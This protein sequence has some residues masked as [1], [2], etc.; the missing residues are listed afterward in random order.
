MLTAAAGQQGLLDVPTL[1]FAAVCVVGFLGMLLLTTWLQQREVR[2]LAW[3][4]SAY[5]I[6]AAAIAQWGAPEPTIRLP[7]EIPEAVIF[8]ACGIVWNGVRLFHG[9]SLWPRAVFGGAIVWLIACQ[10]DGIEEG[11]LGRIVAGAV[12]IAVYTF[13]IAFELARERR[14]SAYSRLAAA[15]VPSF[16]AGMFM[17]PLG[18]Q[19][20]LPEVFAAH[21]LTVLALEAIF[22]AVGTAF[23]LLMMVKDHHV[24]FYRKAAT[25]DGLTGLLNRRAFIEAATAM[26]KA[27]GARGE[28]V[29]LLMFD[30]DHFK[31][32]NDRFGHATGDSV[33]KVFA[34]TATGSV[35]A[36]DIVARLGG[37]EFVAMVP[38]SIEGACHVAERLRAAYETAGLMVDDIAVGSTVSIGLATSYRPVADIDALLLRAD[39]ALYLAKRE[40]RN[41]FRCAPEEPG[42]D[43][44][45]VRMAARK[46]PDEG[47]VRRWVAR[48]PKA[49]DV[50]AGRA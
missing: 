27:Q 34:Q 11:S 17:V 16:Y 41:R 30:L 15:V 10:F 13:F 21:W 29:T 19:A 50:A 40:G 4:G 3:W 46:K 43:E 42:S 18:M 25:T 39:E 2:A 12:T 49:A 6:G 33:L 20:F 44:A 7:P 31:S 14:K 1:V 32:V 47:M 23:I 35:R 26:Q 24:H 8:V 37:E 36:T 45:R 38:E 48:R 28:P 5:L 9:R 22:Y